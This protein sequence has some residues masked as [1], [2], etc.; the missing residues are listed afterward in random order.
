M[1]QEEPE[2]IGSRFGNCSVPWLVMQKERLKQPLM[3]GWELINP[4]W[5]VGNCVELPPLLNY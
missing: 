5:R 3:A 1:T 4:S 2:L